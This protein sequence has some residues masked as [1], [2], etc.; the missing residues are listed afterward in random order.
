MWY[1]FREHGQ[2]LLHVSNSSGKESEGAVECNITVLND[3][4]DCNI[5]MYNHFHQHSNSVSKDINSLFYVHMTPIYNL[6]YLAYYTT[7]SK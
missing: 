2:Y 3:P 4:Q 6:E 5:R 7:K 1:H